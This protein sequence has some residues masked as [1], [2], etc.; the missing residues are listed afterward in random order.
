MHLIHLY[1]P[2]SWKTQHLGEEY[3]GTVKLLRRKHWLTDEDC[4]LDVSSQAIHMIHLPVKMKGVDRVKLMRA[5]EHHFHQRCF[6]EHDCCGHWFGGV[7]SVR[8]TSKRDIVVTTS[9]S[10]NV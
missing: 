7:R 1:V 5:I 10:R 4:S 6:C 2:T 9:Y 3:L 8:F